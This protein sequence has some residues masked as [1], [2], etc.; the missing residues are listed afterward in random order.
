MKVQKSQLLRARPA[1][2]GG[3]SG[4]EGVSDTLAIF[5]ATFPMEECGEVCLFLLLLMLDTKSLSTA[6]VERRKAFRWS[7]LW[8]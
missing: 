5:G 1:K 8:V 4:L 6:L 2:G 7:H 3:I